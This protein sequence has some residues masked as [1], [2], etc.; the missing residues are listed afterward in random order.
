M[1]VFAIGIKLADNLSVQGSR[2]ADAREHR[3][4][5]KFYNQQQRFHRCLPFRSGVLGSRKLRDIVAG[6]LQR[7][8]QATARQGNRLI[9]T[10][11]PSIVGLQ[12]RQPLLSNTILNPFGGRGAVS[13]SFM[14]HSGHGMPAPLQRQVCSPSHG[15]SG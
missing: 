13:P 10:P 11:M 5:I 3:R 15:R 14:L 8:E 1:R 6:V 9:K 12:R 4:P 7:D 2:D